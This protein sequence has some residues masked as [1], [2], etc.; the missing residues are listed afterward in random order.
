M[1]TTL[2]DFLILVTKRFVFIYKSFTELFV[3]LMQALYEICFQQLDGVAH[4]KC[5]QCDKVLFTHQGELEL[6]V[7]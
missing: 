2:T 5:F 7:N 6:H 3:S 1:Q 4:F